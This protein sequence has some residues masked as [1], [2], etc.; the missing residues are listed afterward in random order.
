MNERDRR[1]RLHVAKVADQLRLGRI[2]RRRFVR[3]LTLAGFG[4]ASARYL[5]GCKPHH[6]TAHS[7]APAGALQSQKQFLR[8]VGGHFKGT[9]I[10]IVSEDTRPSLIIS[11]LMKEEFTPLTG[12]EVEWEIVPLDQVLADTVRDTLAGSAGNYG[13]NDIYYWDQAWLAR[14]AN[15]SVHLDELQ[16][17]N[18]FA[19]PGYDFHDFLP[20]LVDATASVNGSI[21]GIPF[22]IPIFIMMYR[23]DIFEALHL[24]VPKTMTEYLAAVRTIHEAKHRDG[25]F[26]TAGQWK[27]GHY[28]LQSEATAWLWSHGGHHFDKDGKPDY[29]TDGNRKGLQYM[30]EL[31]QY[32]DPES[33]GWDW[34]GQFNAFAG[35]RA[36]L[37]ISWSEFFPGFDDPAQSKVVGLVEAAD[38]PNEDAKLTREECG[39]G[40]IPGISRQGGS[41]LALSRHAPNPD[42]AWIFM[43]WATSA[44][45]TARAN[46]LGSNTPT[47][48][49]NFADA[50]VKEKEQHG[51]GTTRHFEVTRRA[52]E[53]RMGTGPRLPE[54]PAMATEINATEYGRMTSKEQSVE[55]TLE[56]IQRRTKDALTAK[57]S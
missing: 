52:I 37:V 27:S 24:A 48:A 31:G 32:L 3:E 16:E 20:Q 15:D 11:K 33:T 43:Q 44:D 10:R 54:W 53:T 57:K 41:C 36:G 18:D 49:S 47:R 34:G 30:M 25:I 38:C 39:Y 28:A 13:R 55:Q 2:D 14:F 22:D 4:I 5:S 35:G 29:L 12:I 6:V 51:V 23:R 45:V 7:T 1:E 56:A 19:Y 21:I 8:E 9:K 40:E 46:A 50:R 17:K 26:G 42:A